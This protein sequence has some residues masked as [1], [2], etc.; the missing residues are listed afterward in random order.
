MLK[1]SLVYRTA[2]MSLLVVSISHSQEA[3]VTRAVFTSS[4]EDREPVDSL[5]TLSLE[6][7]TIF[8]FTELRNMEDKTVKHRWVY[9]GETLA[10]VAFEVGGPRW[11]VHSSKNLLKSWSGNWTVEVVDDAGDVLHTAHFVYGGESEAMGMEKQ[12]TQEQPATE[13]SAESAMEPETPS[14]TTSSEQ[15]AT[16]EHIARAVFTT[17]VAD[18]E[19]VDAVDTLHT[20]ISKIFFFT[21]L[22]DM[23]GQQVTHRWLFGDEVKADV[24]FDVGAERWRVHSSKN[25]QA[26]WTGKWTV[27]VVDAEG[28]VLASESFVYA[29][30]P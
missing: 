22:R 25:L 19:P 12:D 10:E 17:E 27:E 8:F 1:W 14:A 5:A 30:S 29:Q 15:A 16:S 26:E 13:T 3:A 20:A 24:S 2:L 11:R 7:S 21:E 6:D 9:G 23:A 28:S 18:R 4:V